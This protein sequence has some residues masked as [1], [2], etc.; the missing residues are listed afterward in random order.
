MIQKRQQ[1]EKN[2]FLFQ[3]ATK[4]SFRKSRKIEFTKLTQISQEISQLSR[5]SVSRKNFQKYEGN[6]G[7]KEFLQKKRKISENASKNRIQEKKRFIEINSER[8]KNKSDVLIPLA[9]IFPISEK[10]EDIKENYENL[11]NNEEEKFKWDNYMNQAYST[12]KTES[13]KIQPE[14]NISYRRTAKLIEKLRHKKEEQ[15]RKLEMERKIKEQKEKEAQQKYQQKL[16]EDKKLEENKAAQLEE[17]KRSQNNIQGDD[18][19]SMAKRYI[20]FKQ[21]IYDSMEKGNPPK[22]DCERIIGK[23]RMLMSSVDE[24]AIP[25][26]TLDF[27]QIYT[28]TLRSNNPQLQEYYF[29][30]ISEILKAQIEINSKTTEENDP[31]RAQMITYGKL[32]FN[33]AKQIN[34]LYGF[35]ISFCYAENPSLIPDI[36]PAGK[37]E[38][39]YRQEKGYIVKTRT[40]ISKKSDRIGK[41]REMELYGLTTFFCTLVKFNKEHYLGAAWI[42]FNKILNSHAS[43]HTPLILKTLMIELGQIFATTY[44][45]QYENC[46]KFISTEY[47]TFLQGEAKK[48]E[49]E[50]DIFLANVRQVK[51]IADEQLSKLFNIK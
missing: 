40:G 46:L 11:Q 28:E 51:R 8:V 5:R 10:M 42:S 2:D 43:N 13:I 44:K 26:K 7:S 35:L 37:T 41:N 47:F 19:I 17:Q 31:G 16:E 29:Y 24:K 39:E 6:S 18:P 34:G 33:L 1:K 49:I 3:N 21:R 14:E 50:E 36:N 9:P 4:R 38:T 48:F 25:S 32:Y 15:M 22:A 27:Y 23:I 12:I 20:S 30:A 45:K